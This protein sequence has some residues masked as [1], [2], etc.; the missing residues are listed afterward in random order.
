[1]MLELNS[2]PPT[3]FVESSARPLIA[4]SCLKGTPVEDFFTQKYEF[5]TMICD[6]TIYAIKAG[7]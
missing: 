6:A 4:Q 7:Q 2:H 1:M 3:Y 5:K